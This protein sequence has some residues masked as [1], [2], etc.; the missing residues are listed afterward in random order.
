MEKE[1]T[2][3]EKADEEFELSTLSLARRCSTEL[4]PLEGRDDPSALTIMQYRRALSQ[5][6][7]VNEYEHRQ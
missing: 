1:E 6:S 4:Q 7:G 2:N 3:L 5:P